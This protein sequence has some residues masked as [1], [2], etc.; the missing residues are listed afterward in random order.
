MRAPF[1]LCVAVAILFPLAKPLPGGVREVILVKEGP[2]ISRFE[3]VSGQ[4]ISENSWLKDGTY[5]TSPV[6][7]MEQKASF[8]GG[9]DPF[10]GSKTSS[11]EVLNDRLYTAAHRTLPIGTIVR[12][13]N[14]SNGRWVVVRI[15]D[16]GPFFRGRVIDLSLAA[17]TAI[18]LDRA[19]LAPVTVEI[20]R[21]P[22]SVTSDPGRTPPGGTSPRTAP[23][24]RPK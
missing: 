16:R 19:G 24:P 5:E 17:A 20:L 4:L 8:Y 10:T 2:R 22:P 21:F 6:G 12:V 18:D 14:R 11:G 23:S 3:Y 15:N 7:P 9:G 1:V 13:T